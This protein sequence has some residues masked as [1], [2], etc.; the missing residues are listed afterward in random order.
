MKRK[1]LDKYAYLFMVPIINRLSEKYSFNRE[2]N[3]E[4][5]KREIILLPV[6]KEG[7]IDFVFM[8]SFMQEVEADIL[9]TTLKVFKDR[10]NANENKM[11]GG[12]MESIYPF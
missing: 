4:R 3:D 5:I 7:E 8:S 6:N 9:K 10:L 11:G 1:G 2:I 12:K